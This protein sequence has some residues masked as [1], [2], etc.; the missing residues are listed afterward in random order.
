MF[1]STVI[2]T[3]GRATLG[4]AVQ[5]VLS[6]VTDRGDFEVIVVNDS[7]RELPRADWQ[8]S[9]RVRVIDTMRHE[10]SVAR[11]TG[12]AVAKGA[13]LHFLDDDDALLPGGL[14]A[15]WT[16]AR[17][18]S[19]AIWLCGNWR[20]VDDHGTLV[21][22]FA[23][24]LNG[25]IFALLVAGEGL[26]LQASLV[27]TPRF[28]EVG[29]FD[30][31]PELTGVEDRDLGRR[32]ALLGSI[33]C[34]DVPV[35]Q[36]RIGEASSTTDWTRIAERDRYGRERALSALNAFARLRASASS[37][38][39]RG[40]VSRAYMAS[41]VWNVQHRKILTAFSRATLGMGIAGWHPLVP[42]YWR[43]LRTRIS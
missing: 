14:Q 11:N 4:R 12:A 26:P 7:G 16:L 18:A 27:L 22:E 32:L 35:A 10:R 9:P 41:A 17:A 34:T 36:V 25:N 42:D 40:R 5:S 1:S 43:G 24:G 13:Y 21:A 6:Q 39:L 38:R 23:P 20:T 8:E 19:D 31:S 3:I 2:P 33:A 37:A 30:A 15:L 28:F 29:G